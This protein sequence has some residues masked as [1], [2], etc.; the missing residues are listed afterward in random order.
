MIPEILRLFL[1]S[2]P[3]DWKQQKHSFSFTFTLHTITATYILYFVKRSYWS[4]VD[5]QCVLGHPSK[6]LAVVAPSE[7][8]FKPLQHIQNT[9]GETHVNTT[10]K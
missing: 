9:A 7:N 8:K 3:I 10:L 2:K 5:A 1:S 4:L 6:E